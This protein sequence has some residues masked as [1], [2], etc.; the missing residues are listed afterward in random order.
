MFIIIISTR[1]FQ[2][3]GSL[4]KP[5]FAG[6]ELS[7]QESL[8]DES[9]WQR[10]EDY[11]EQTWPMGTHIPLCAEKAGAVSAAVPTPI[12]QMRQLKVRYARYMLKVTMSHG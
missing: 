11:V 2:V 10:L 1:H 6:K 12:S 8:G 7:C 9:L 5:L 4:C 3:S